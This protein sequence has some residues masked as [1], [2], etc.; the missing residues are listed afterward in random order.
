MLFI[1]Y[2]PQNL[3]ITA[4]V[5]PQNARYNTFSSPNQDY[6]AVMPEDLLNILEA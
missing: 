4:I 6:S 1:F 3:A 2:R 5:E